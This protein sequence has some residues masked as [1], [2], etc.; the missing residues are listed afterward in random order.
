MFCFKPKS[1][2]RN[3]VYHLV[4]NNIKIAELNETIF[5]G[6]RPSLQHRTVIPEVF[7][8]YCRGRIQ[9]E[10]NNFAELK[11]MLAEKA[12]GNYGTEGKR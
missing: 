3:W 10:P 1:S 2:I 9:A 5:S 4:L 8:L 12:T 11:S 6:H 7:K